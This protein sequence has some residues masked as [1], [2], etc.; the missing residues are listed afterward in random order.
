MKEVGLHEDDRYKFHKLVEVKST[1]EVILI[2]TEPVMSI[3]E[4]PQSRLSCIRNVTGTRKFTYPVC[5]R[6][7]ATDFVYTEIEG[8]YYLVMNCLRCGMKLLDL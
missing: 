6:I 4:V 5:C 8:K 2:G 3:K 7:S 1:G